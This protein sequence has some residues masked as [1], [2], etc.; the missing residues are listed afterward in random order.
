MSPKINKKQGDVHKLSQDGNKLPVR[1]FAGFD[2]EFVF[3]LPLIPPFE[4]ILSCRRGWQVQ[5]P[6]VF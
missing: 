6:F 5:R 3:F 4:M 1:R 2:L